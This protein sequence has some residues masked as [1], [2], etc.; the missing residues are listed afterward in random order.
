M[1][2]VS[3]LEVLLHGKKIATLTHV[4]GDRALFAFTEEYINDQSRSILGLGFKDSLGQLITDSKPTRTRVIPWFSNLLPEGQLRQYLAERAHVKSVREFFLLW[5]LGQDL[6]GAVV[7]QPADGEEYPPTVH[8]AYV[9]EFREKALRFSLA[10]VQLKFS[11][12]TN[13]FNGLTIPI[14]GVG[15]DRIVKFPSRLYDALPE[16]E[17]SMME[18]ARDIG[19]DV[20][21]G[22]LIKADAIEN[23]PDDIDVFGTHAF[24]VDR[25]D[26]LSGRNPIHAEDFAQIFGVYPEVKYDKAS[27]RNIATVVGIE[28][29]QKD[30]EEFV[31]R[32]VFNVLIGNADMHLKNWSLIYMDQQNASLA[33]AYDF[34]S[35]IC[36]IPSETFALKFS[37]TKRFAEFSLNELSHLAGKARLPEKLVLNT[38]VETVTRFHEVWRAKKNNLVL[39]KDMVAAIDKHMESVPIARE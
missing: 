39:S 13:A 31:R 17:Y 16:N 11:A 25:F 26:R 23:L 28:S 32:L 24:A 15:G 27:I 34:V 37:R 7:V 33:P 35:T 5:V 9:E 1:P 36:Y 18:L 20:P 10:G 38:A 30:I 6:P 22:E 29:H 3:V 8:L 2:D 12:V 14:Q 19:I 21:P 4:A